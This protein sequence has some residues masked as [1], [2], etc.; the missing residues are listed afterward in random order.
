MRDRHPSKPRAFA[1]T[2]GKL[3]PRIEM[4]NS[5]ATAN[6]NSHAHPS[7][8]NIS[9]LFEL[10]IVIFYAEAYREAVT[11][12]LDHFHDEGSILWP[13]LLFFIFFFVTVRFF[14]GN[15]F[16]LADK[17]WDEKRKTATNEEVARWENSWTRS[18]YFFDTLFIVLESLA[19]I[20]LGGLATVGSS[21]RLL[22]ALLIIP[23]CIDVIWICCRS[24]FDWLLRSKW[25]FNLF[26]SIFRL[27]DSSN[28]PSPA[29]FE[30]FTPH[31]KVH[32]WALLNI[33][34]IIFLGYPLYCS[35]NPILST[36]ILWGILGINFAAFVLDVIV[37]DLFRALKG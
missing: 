13:V 5:S 7:F 9:H 16:H 25:V 19:M 14:V 32:I 28:G 4:A 17:N 18:L 24:L 8:E 12:G 36:R 27:P 21:V 34:V 10:L 15:Y 29:P 30:Q 37:I 3:P 1:A 23:P 35:W 20:L 26:K 31:V 6:S 2:N 11:N 33:M 22:A